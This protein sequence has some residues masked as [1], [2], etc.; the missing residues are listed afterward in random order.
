MAYEN[1]AGLNVNN[2]YGARVTGNAVGVERTQD[3]IHQLSFEFTGTS[4]NETFV[5]PVYIPKGALFLRYRLRIDEAFVISA[6]GTL[7]IGGTLPGTNGVVLTEAELENI[8][9]KTPASAGAGTWATTSATGTTASERVGKV[10][11]GT[12]TAGV[13]KGCL[14]AEYIFKTLV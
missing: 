14:I 8:G 5:P 7:A 9:T 10:L 12:A 6:A 1:S 11:T 2:Q 4:L 13:G 3:S